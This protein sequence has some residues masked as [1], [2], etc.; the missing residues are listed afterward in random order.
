MTGP[1]GQVAHQLARSSGNLHQ[2]KREQGTPRRERQRQVGEQQQASY[3][4][5]RSRSPVGVAHGGGGQQGP[6]E[7]QQRPQPRVGNTMEIVATENVVQRIG[8]QYQ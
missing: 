7:Q 2:Q 8:P 1:P 6:G 3:E 5:G 4:A